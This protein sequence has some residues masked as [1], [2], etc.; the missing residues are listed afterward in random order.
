MCRL[1]R[2]SSKKKYWCIVAL[3]CCIHFCW[4]SKWSISPYTYIPSFFWILF[5]L[6][7][8]NP[9][10]WHTYLEKTITIKD[11]W[12]PVSTIA[13]FTIA[14]TWR[15]LKCPLTEEWIKRMWYIYTT[16]LLFK[17]IIQSPNST[18]SKWPK[19]PQC[20]LHMPCLS[21]VAASWGNLVLSTPDM[22][23]GSL[24]GKCCQ[25]FKPQVR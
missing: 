13:L 20:A 18:F 9:T 10:P 1:K 25:F 19:V 8:S 2:L 7:P 4:T 22:V 11:S 23:L 17:T 16:E 24:A 14:R 3:Q 12:A 6:G 15:H 5:H 21:L